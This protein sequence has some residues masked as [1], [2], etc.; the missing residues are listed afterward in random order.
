MVQHRN[1]II[2]M[3]DESLFNEPSARLAFMI[4]FDASVFPSTIGVC[5]SEVFLKGID[6]GCPIRR[7]LNLAVK[8]V[9]PTPTHE[10]KPKRFAIVYPSMRIRCGHTIEVVP[11]RPDLASEMFGWDTLQRSQDSESSVEAAHESVEHTLSP[12]EEIGLAQLREIDRLVLSWSH[13]ETQ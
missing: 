9:A 5:T 10:P 6:R 4:I 8:K 1:D 2:K 12:E 13:E 7:R 3:R 11:L